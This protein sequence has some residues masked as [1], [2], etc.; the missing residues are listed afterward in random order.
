MYS[1]WRCKHSGN[2]YGEMI[3]GKEHR[4]ANAH[5]KNE[6]GARSQLDNFM[7]YQDL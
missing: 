6:A 7:A 5:N 1:T 4:G 2:F 3:S